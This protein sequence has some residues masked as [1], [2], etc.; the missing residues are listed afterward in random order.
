MF[1]GGVDTRTVIHVLK[2]PIGFRVEV[3]DFYSGLPNYN[4]KH[5]QSS[6]QPGVHWRIIDQVLRPP[7]RVDVP[8]P[9]RA[10][11]QSPINFKLSPETLSPDGSLIYGLKGELEQG[12][13]LKPR[14]VCCVTELCSRADR[15]GHPCRQKALM[16]CANGQGERAKALSGRRDYV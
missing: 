3:R 6:E 8:N 14:S 10:S 16:R 1:G 7:T 11:H 5:R 2:I 9:V 4:Q 15:R 13:H 12:A